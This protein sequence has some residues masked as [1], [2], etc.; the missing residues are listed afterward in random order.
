MTKSEQLFERAQK[1]LPGGVNSPVR[2]FKAVGGTPPFIVAARGC[3][4]EDSDGRCYIDYVGSWGPMILGHSHSTVVRALQEAVPRGTSFGMPS[5]TEVELAEEIVRR[6][7]SIEMIR[8]VNS[9]T[10]A[11]MSAIRLARAATGRPTILKFSGCYHG[12]ADSFLIQAGSGVAT[13]GLPDSPGVTRGAA[14]DTRIAPFNDF[15]AVERLFDREG[16][17]M[18]AVIVEPV[19]GNMGVVPPAEGFL[20]GL[21]SLCDRN[22][23]LLIFDE[24]MTGFRVHPAGAQ[25][26]FGIRPDLTAFG[27]V[28]GGGLPVG[29]YGGR[30]DLMQRISPSG[31]VY[32]AG[33]LSGNPLAMTAGLA[34]LHELTEDAYAK[35]ER[36]SA[37]LAQGLRNVCAEKR[38]AAQVQRVGSMLT[39]FFGERPVTNMEDASRA[40]HGKYAR[41][42]RN[43]LASGVHLPPSGYEAWFVS[44]AHNDST[45]ERTIAAAAA[46]LA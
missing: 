20:E 25:G 27:K 12:H 35:L 22:H 9:G 8:F 33:T 15:A 14:Q 7:P 18:A 26:L 40:D 3:T 1:V 46:A 19:C 43:L 5:P 29:A 38:I 37:K 39:L 31:P 17:S 42:F 45:V 21:R 32:Q 11:T 41:F 13:L 34:T 16:D 30:A 36:T 23:S 4:L 10:E 24:V 6:V 28:I 44:L 2:A